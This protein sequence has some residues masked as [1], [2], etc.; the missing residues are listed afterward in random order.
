MRLI[1][2]IWRSFLAMEVVNLFCAVTAFCAEPKPDIFEQRRDCVSDEVG[3]MKLEKQQSSG[4]L[5]STSQA[6]IANSHDPLAR[7][8]ERDAEL[9]SY[10]VEAVLNFAEHLILDAV[11]LWT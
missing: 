10:D 3:Q 11:R 4:S 6:G 9:E 5:F 2:A 7:M 1:F 8:R